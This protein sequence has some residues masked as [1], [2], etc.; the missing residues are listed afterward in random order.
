MARALR[1]HLRALTYVSPV[2]PTSLRLADI[3]ARLQQRATGINLLPRLS[4]FAAR[5]NARVIERALAAEPADL[6]FAP[7][8]STMIA[9]LETDLPIAYSSDATVR[10]MIDYYGEFSGLTK[11]ARRQAE[12]VEA[13]AIARA[14]VLIYPTDW[15]AQSAIEDYG[16]DPA[17]VVIA[18]YGANFDVA[19][20]PQPSPPTGRPLQLIFVGVDW[21]RKGGAIAVEALDTL[22]AAGHDA[23]LTVVGCTPP[24]EIPRD[25]ITVYPFLSKSNP[26]QAATLSRLYR[27]ADLMLLP[28]RAECF[29]VVFCEAAGHGLPSI[30]TATGGVPDVVHDG[31]TGYCLPHAAGG[32]AYAERIAT[33]AENPDQLAALRNS[34]L[35]DFRTRLNW[36]SWA[37][38]AAQ[39]FAKLT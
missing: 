13:E 10:L 33:L 3:A 12:A 19:A 26:D 22:V 11:A 28:T 8:G 35:E 5:A 2:A 7:A 34:A 6:L 24:S 15:V 23:H 31:T 27:E 37:I 4:W 9:A 1:P 32:A 20:G 36:E 21:V 14:N 16:A 17:K 25:R 30:T 29:G 38:R 39:S 18:P